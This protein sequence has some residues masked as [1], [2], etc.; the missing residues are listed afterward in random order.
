M[1]QNEVFKKL[2]INCCELLNRKI[3]K[4][5]FFYKLKEKLIQTVTTYTRTIRKRNE[6]FTRL[7]IEEARSTKYFRFHGFE[8]TDVNWPN[9]AVGSITGRG[10]SNPRVTIPV[11]VGGSLAR[12]RRNSSCKYSLVG[13]TGR[14]RQQKFDFGIC[15]G[16]PQECN[17]DKAWKPRVPSRQYS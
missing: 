1:L 12:N 16:V 8:G 3:P 7:F 9:W 2:I 6:T 5:S 11:S 17:D 4:I 13:V 14:E 10:R 15:G